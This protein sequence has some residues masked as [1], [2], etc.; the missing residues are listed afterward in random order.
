[1]VGTFR[2]NVR[3]G[4]RS[5]GWASRPYLVMAGAAGRP[6][7]GASRMIF[8]LNMAKNRVF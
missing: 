3:L 1:M 5:D 2:R 4:F 7:G 8:G 6:V